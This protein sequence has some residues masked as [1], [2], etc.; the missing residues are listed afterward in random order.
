V[1]EGAARWIVRFCDWSSVFAN[2]RMV[3]DAIVGC[4]EMEWK[5]WCVYASTKRLA[6]TTTENKQNGCTVALTKIIAQGSR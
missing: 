6:N 1:I 3:L 2:G 4:V 5:E